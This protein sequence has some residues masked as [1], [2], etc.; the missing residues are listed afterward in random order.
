M[1][2]Q[3]ISKNSKVTILKH[4]TD[5]W[6]IV[7]I[8][9]RKTSQWKWF[10]SSMDWSTSSS[11]NLQEKYMLRVHNI[12]I[13]RHIIYYNHIIISLKYTLIKSHTINKCQHLYFHKCLTFFHCD[14]FL[15]YN[16]TIYSL[17][18]ILCGKIWSDTEFKK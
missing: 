7:S 10:C 1:S 2:K 18:L 6:K 16:E 5:K 9:E 14:V 12:Y 17:C 11:H 4:L 8:F 15:S 13:D 3:N